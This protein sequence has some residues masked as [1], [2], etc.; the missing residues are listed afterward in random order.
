LAIL[1]MGGSEQSLWAALNAPAADQARW[2][3][4]NPLSPR[5][6][7]NSRRTVLC[8][9]PALLKKVCA[10]E[11]PQAA[12][13][14]LPEIAAALVFASAPAGP[15]HQKPARRILLPSASLWHRPPPARV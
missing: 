2:A 10:A 13:F 15:L 12:A 3:N 9:V 1:F 8:L 5:D 7:Q 14:V 4:Q 11:H 6:A